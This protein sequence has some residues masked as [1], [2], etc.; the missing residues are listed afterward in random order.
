[1]GWSDGFDLVVELCSASKVGMCVYQ[2]AYLYGV[3][4]VDLVGIHAT[5]P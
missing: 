5:V 3:M 2:A 1:M 4:R